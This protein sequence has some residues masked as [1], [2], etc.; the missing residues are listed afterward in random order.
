MFPSL[1]LGEQSTF[2]DDK[3]LNFD[4]IAI[5]AYYWLVNKCR[6]SLIYFVLQGNRRNTKDSVA[7]AQHNKNIKIPTHIHT[8]Q[9]WR[10]DFITGPVEV[11]KSRSLSYS[12]ISNGN[13]IRYLC[14]RLYFEIEACNK[15]YVQADVAWKYVRHKYTF[16]DIFGHQFYLDSNNAWI[17]RMMPYNLNKLNIFQQEKLQTKLNMDGSFASLFYFFHLKVALQYCK[18]EQCFHIKTSAS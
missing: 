14:S 4:L 7:P 17:W 13:V 10:L 5:N 12:W 16:Y 15:L 1:I 9:V 18:R 3:V 6:V 2:R 8:C 11:I